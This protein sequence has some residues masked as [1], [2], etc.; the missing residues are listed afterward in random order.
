MDTTVTSGGVQT[1]FANGTALDTIVSFGGTLNVS[2]GGT[3]NVTSGGTS[4]PITT[5]ASAGGLNVFS[6]AYAQNIIASNGAHLGIA[7]AP[8]T[9]AQGAYNSSAFVMSSASIS[10]YTIHSGCKLDVLSGGMANNTTV[11]SSGGMNV[12]SGGTATVINAA[13]GALLGLAVAPNTYASGSY[14][15]I[16]FEVSANSITS[17]TVQ[18]GCSLDVLTG[19]VAS[20]TTVLFGGMLRFAGGTAQGLTTISSGGKMSVALPTTIG[21]GMNVSAT[22][23][24]I[25]DFDISNLSPANTALINNLSLIQGAPDYSITVSGTNAYGLYTLANG[26]PLNYSGSMELYRESDSLGTLSVG[27][28]IS[29]DYKKYLLKET[30]NTLSLNIAERR[31]RSDINQNRKSDVIFYESSGE[32]RLGYWL[33]GTNTWLG[34]SPLSSGWDVLG[35]YDMNSD[36]YADLV[37]TMKGTSFVEIRYFGSGT[38]SPGASNYTSIGSRSQASLTEWNVKVGNLTGNTGKNSIVWHNTSSGVLDV[39]KDGTTSSTQLGSYATSSGW[40]MQGCGDF[41]GDGKDSVLM[42]QNGFFYSVELDGTQTSLGSL[43]WSASD[44]WEVRAIGD[45]SGDGKDDIMLFMAQNNDAAGCIVLLPDGDAVNYQTVGQLNAYIG[46]APDWSI[47]GCG[48]YNGDGKDD[49]LVKQSS[50]TILG[51]YSEGI[52]DTSHWV[53]MGNGVNGWEIIA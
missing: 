7:V 12:L 16:Q 13:S 40:A 48:D 36:G 3:L 37:A 35:G 50:T 26:A 43:A 14:G 34:Q 17:Y 15:G 27:G 42:S 45:F 4:T 51:Y 41:N 47:V 8:N 33:D 22:T 29:R 1:V 9:Y 39:W 38:V 31:I 18:S 25:V 6:G 20:D 23:G 30:G 52:Q 2:T 21:N 5:V 46:N 32:H 53:N 49:L 10:N 24:A 11:N 19:G 44:G 28:T